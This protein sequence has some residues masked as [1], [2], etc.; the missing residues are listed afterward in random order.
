MLLA[1]IIVLPV[2]LFRWALLRRPLGKVAAL[3]AAAIL[4]L[5]FVFVLQ[6]FGVN[7][8]IASFAALLAYFIL[9]ARSTEKKLSGPPIA[10]PIEPSPS[11]A[12]SSLPGFLLCFALGLVLGFIGFKIAGERYYVERDGAYLRDRWTGK[13]YYASGAVWRER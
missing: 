10:S 3:G 4:W 8:T 11:Q 12:V 6:G 7:A 13:L 9:R 5:F 1:F 2:V